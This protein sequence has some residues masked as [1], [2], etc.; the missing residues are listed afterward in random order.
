MAV[1]KTQVISVRVG[2]HINFALQLVAE[3]EIRSVS[4]MLEVMVVSYCMSK[5]YSLEGVPQD[6][7]SILAK[8]KKA[9]A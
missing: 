9:S 4:N 5:R 2:P 8:A 1:T 7:L 6:V 3:K